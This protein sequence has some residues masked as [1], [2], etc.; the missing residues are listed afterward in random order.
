MELLNPMKYKI[1]RI[2]VLSKDKYGNELRDKKGKG[3]NRISLI[4][5]EGEGK[6]GIP[7]SCF[8]YPGSPALQWREGDVIDGAITET[9]GYLNFKPF[10]TSTTY[11]SGQNTRPAPVQAVTQNENTKKL[12][13]ILS[14]L[15]MI[16]LNTLA[17]MKTLDTHIDEEAPEEEPN[18]LDFLDG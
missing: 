3:Y 5:S 2:T 17:I 18:Q 7:C 10:F 1:E 15:E 9:N 16:Q 4:L 14:V 11:G 12:D 8:A 13:K 6:Q